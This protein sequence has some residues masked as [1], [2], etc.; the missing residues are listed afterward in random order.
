M[1]I[2]VNNPEN[3][4]VK[5]FTIY[6]SEVSH[7]ISESFLE[8]IT[9]SIQAKFGIKRN[10]YYLLPTEGNITWLQPTRELVKFHFFL[11]L[12]KV[13]KGYTYI[14]IVNDKK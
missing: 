11:R 1:A 14:M 5:I 8:S 3:L 2:I 12:L 10:N 6:L 13:R 4:P 9:K 7:F